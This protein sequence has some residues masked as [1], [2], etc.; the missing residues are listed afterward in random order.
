[1]TEAQLQIA[2]AEYITTKYPKVLFHSDFGSGV[3]LT[4]GQARVNKAQNAGRRGWPDVFIAQP[5]VSY[6]GEVRYPGLFLELK[7]DGVR[8]R[9]KDGSWASQHIAE[10][11]EILLKLQKNDYCAV[12]AVGLDQA[13]RAI[14]MY[15]GDSFYL[16]Y[17]RYGD[18][19]ALDGW[20]CA[21][22]EQP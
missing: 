4:P 10:Q 11:A 13:I 5:I 22:E 3:K 1:M 15:L 6:S 8:L 16:Y 2:V 14:D 9:K 12:F 18:S 20:Y 19:S 21:L 17:L 7:A